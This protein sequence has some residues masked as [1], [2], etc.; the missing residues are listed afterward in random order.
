MKFIANY[1]LLTIVVF[2]FNTS[3]QFDVF[4][5]Y[6]K[7]QCGGKPR[8]DTVEYFPYANQKLIVIYNGGTIDTLLTS[9]KGKIKIKNKRGVYNIFKSW[10]YY[11]SFPADFPASYYDSLCIKE[12]WNKP[13]W[14]IVVSSSK[15]YKITPLFLKEYCPD[16]HPCISKENNIPKIQGR[17]K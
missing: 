14:I 12:E 8:K 2:S 3:A 17:Q 7:T 9:P 6:K 15:K 5:K 10:K 1:F 13:D 11:H 16:K 4:L